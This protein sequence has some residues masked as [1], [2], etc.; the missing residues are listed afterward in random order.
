M[1]ELSHHDLDVILERSARLHAELDAL[2]QALPRPATKRTTVVLA[3]CAIVR[4]HVLSQHR[5][6]A[7][8]LDVTS[9]TLVRPA[10]ESLVRAIWALAGSEDR[11]V[12]QFLTAPADDADPRAETI[13]GPPVDSMLAVIQ[14]HHPAWVHDALCALKEATWK[15]MHS[16]VHGGIRP[17][18]QVLGGCPAYQQIAVARNA[19]GFLVFATDVMR[20]ACRA[21]PWGWRGCN[22]ATPTASRRPQIPASTCAQGTSPRPRICATRPSPSSAAAREAVRCSAQFNVAVLRLREE[23]LHPRQ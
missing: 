22:R 7:S 14:K 20:M 2:W 21:A 10:Y 11:W 9:M 15:P 13:T 17:V 1:T 23:L 8:G 6:L 18:A 5:L 4:Q 19:N 16:Y 12:E 3:Y